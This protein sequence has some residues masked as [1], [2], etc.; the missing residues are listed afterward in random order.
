MMPSLLKPVLLLS[1]LLSTGAYAQTLCNGHAELCDRIYSSVSQIG[2]HDS[3]FVGNLPSDNQVKSVTDQ[4]NAGIRFLSAQSHLDSFK[5]LSL[6]HTSCF[7]EDAGSV[8]NYLGTIRNWLDA[9]PNDVVTVLLTNGDNVDV[10]LF[11]S[12]FAASGI[13]PYAYVPPTTPLA[14]D[15]WPKL[16]DMIKSNTR[17]VAFLDAG[18]TSAFPYI[19][20]EFTYFFETPYDT[21]DPNFPEC[22]LDRPAKGDPK[23]RMYIVNHFLDT[24]I[25]GVLVPDRG[26][27]AVTNAATGAGSIGAQVDICRGLY[28]GQAPKGVLVDNFDVGDVFSAERALNGL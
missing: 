8:E 21:T 12:A 14:I 19:L 15:A 3:A 9:N 10:S 2:T 25:F 26:A 17:L 20:D 11:D 1:A 6:C 23:G 27:D 7:L 5:Q 24:N 28:G 13:K 16:G 4:L 18:A 22:T